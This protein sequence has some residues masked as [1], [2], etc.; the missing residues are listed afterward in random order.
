MYYLCMLMYAVVLTQ[1]VERASNITEVSSL[2]R[3]L[4]PTSSLTYI[5]TT[6]YSNIHGKNNVN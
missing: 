6:Q 2:D 4:P 1:P 5:P 3:P